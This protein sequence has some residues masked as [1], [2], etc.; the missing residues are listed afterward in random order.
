MILT[1][2]Y[3]LV[4]MLLIMCL[5]LSAQDKS[6]GLRG[7]IET[8]YTGINTALTGVYQFNNHAIELGVNYNLSDGFSNSPVIGQ[9]VSYHYKVAERN[10]LSSSIG[11]EYR[12]QK[13]IKIVNIQLVMISMGMEYRF[14]D[15]I[16][17]HSKLGYGLA[18]ERALS[19]QSFSQSNIL[20]GF[21]QL[22]CG[23]Q[24]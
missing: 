10:N 13:P 19:A 17:A 3:S 9:S 16:L 18:S 23:Y 8:N 15:H 20:T 1:F 12:R 7:A 5:N 22:G 21:I 11:L 6:L 2:R 4:L 14:T 24:F